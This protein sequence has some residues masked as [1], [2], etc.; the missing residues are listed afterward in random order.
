MATFGYTTQGTAGNTG[1][2]GQ[3]IYGW[4]YTLS[5]A[6]VVSKLTAYF[7]CPTGTTTRAL[8]YNSS[9]DLVA[10]TEENVYVGAKGWGWDDFTFAS[11]VNLAAG[12]Y[13]LCVWAVGDGSNYFLVAYDAGDENQQANVAQAY[14]GAP[15][16]I[17]WANYWA[18]KA[19]IYA[20][21]TEPSLATA[22]TIGTSGNLHATYSPPTQLSF[23]A[24][25]RFWVFYCTASG[26]T[27]VYRTSTDGESWSSETTVVAGSTGSLFSTAIVDDSHFCYC[28][29]QTTNYT[30]LYYR[31]GTLNS[32]G[33]IS[34]VAAEQTIH[35]DEN[36]GCDPVIAIDSNGYPWIACKDLTSETYPFTIYHSTTKDGTW[37]P[38]SGDP[39][40]LGDYLDSG[41]QALVA[42]TNGKMYFI[43]ACAVSTAPIQARGYLYNGSSWGSM[44]TFTTSYCTD[45]YYNQFSAVAV[46]DDVFFA[47]TEDSTNDITVVRRVYGVGW[48]SETTLESGANADSAPVLFATSVGDVYCC[49]ISTSGVYIAKFDLV[50]GEWGS[51]ELLCDESGQ[52]M[53]NRYL[54]NSTK[55]A[56]SGYFSCIWMTGTSPTWNVRFATFQV[57]TGM[58]LFTVL[59][60]MGY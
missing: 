56:C 53:Y 29:A 23:Y 16:P 11:P 32:D 10:E 37:T 60:E 57:E 17:S 4:K 15:D 39:V 47:F 49:W 52:T 1:T 6:A 26:D 50:D 24:Q 5:E 55:Y 20:T 7:T 31:L 19:S 2:T 34:W 14:N 25:G 48:G 45:N 21:Y 58:Q 54:V 9:Y 13:W 38:A 36:R 43:I 44:E 18:R 8:I 28:R 33:T 51:P 12:D 41:T 35:S 46:G 27:F 30:G 59:N 3:S 40:A 42:L 22:V